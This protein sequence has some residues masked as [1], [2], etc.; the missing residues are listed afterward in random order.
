MSTRERDAYLWVSRTAPNRLTVSAFFAGFTLTAFVGLV[1]VAPSLPHLQGMAIISLLA[2][3]CLASAAFFFIF[4]TMATYV[5]MQRIAVLSRAA[6][7]LLDADSMEF[8]HLHPGDLATLQEG[9]TMYDEAGLFITWGLI[10]VVLGILLVAWHVQLVLALALLIILLMI[11]AKV[12]TLDA[13]IVSALRGRVLVHPV[14]EEE[15]ILA[16]EDATPL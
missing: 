14:A 11:V 8:C 3:V 6:V 12:R 15:T 7:R 16:A 2:D 4:S 5:A 13:G 9:E 1:T 10:L